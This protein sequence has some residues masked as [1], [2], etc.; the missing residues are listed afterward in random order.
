MITYK[1]TQPKITTPKRNIKVEGVSISNGYLVDENGSIADR[2]KDALPSGVED[3]T[4]K[5][6]VLLPEEDNREW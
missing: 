5:I 2:I 4:I 3:F 6:Q 1:D